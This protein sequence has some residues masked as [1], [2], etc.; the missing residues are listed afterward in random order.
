[1]FKPARLAALCLSAA[2]ISACGSSSH[3]PP[4][5]TASRHPVGLRAANG[6]PLPAT[7]TRIISL[8]DASTED[9]FAVGAGKQVVAADE[10][11]TYPPN[12]PRTKLSGFSPNVEAIAS[13]RPDLVVTSQ[14]VGHIESQLAALRIPLLYEPAPAN[15]DGAFAQIEQL[16]QASGHAVQAVALVA[17][18]RRKV[19]AIVASVKKENPPLT[20]YHELDQT[21][22]SASSRSFIGQLY[23][24]LGL[25]NIADAAAKASVY[26]QLSAE[27]IIASRPDLIVLA[28]TVCCG[29]TARTVAARPGW[30][31]ITAVK[32][33]DVLAVDDTVAS[34]W[35]PRIVDFLADVATEVRKIEAQK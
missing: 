24:L 12:A 27:Y 29:Q 10:Y 28:D 18:L 8:T 9:L 15:L 17:E 25:K 7:A 2:L 23:S 34:E 6:V 32:D 26:P 5:L 33:H 30:D 22:Y 20:V 3:H 4:K 14:N 16:G 13:Y 19:R 1:M 11:S 21:Y 35:G 31:D